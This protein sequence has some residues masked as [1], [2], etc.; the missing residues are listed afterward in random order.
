MRWASARR[1]G[2]VLASAVLLLLMLLVVVAAVVIPRGGSEDTGAASRG[3]VPSGARG[4]GAGTTS[5][6]TAGTGSGGAPGVS[7][8]AGP[9]RTAGSPAPSA[10]TTAQ[11][12]T[13]AR[14]A[15][16]T[17]AA[18]YAIDAGWRSGIAIV[19]LRTGATTTAGEATNLFPTE[20]TVKV[21]LAA[22][23][24][25]SGQM[26]GAVADTAKQMIVASDDGAANALYELGGGDDVVDWAAARYGISGLGTPPVNG[27]G[28]WGSTQVTPLGMARFL[29]AAA[30]DPAVG[31]W[32]T[33]TMAQMSPVAADGTDQNFGIKAAAP[34]AAVKQGWGGDSADLDSETT[35]SIGYVDGR[36]AVAIYTLHS[37]EVDQG[38]SQEMVTAQARLLLPD[39]HVPAL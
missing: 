32:L 15:A 2:V 39:G 24:L 25:A 5:G 22:D 21:L 34:A 31:P 19:D 14:Q 27:L 7:S 16:A 6:S 30:N 8:G 36:Y 17:A 23:I 18:A 4:A 26:S 33:S 12:T 37:P 9:S 35:P 20:S 1:S 10:A 38:T 29:A 11:P 28:Q 3:T 13:G